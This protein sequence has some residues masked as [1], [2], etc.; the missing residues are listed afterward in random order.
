MA[1][2]EDWEGYKSGPAAQNAAYGRGEACRSPVFQSIPQDSLAVLEG[3]AI[4][5]Y[6][7]LEDD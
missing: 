5:L 3:D 1:E 2:R 6:G 7:G 4:T